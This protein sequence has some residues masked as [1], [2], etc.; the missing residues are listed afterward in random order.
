MPSSPAKKNTAFSFEISLPSEAGSTF[1]VDPTLE[2]G[3]VT[4]S[5]DG[6]AFANIA[7]LP[8]VIGSGSTLTVA[9]TS[10]EMNADRVVVA[11]HDAAGAE[12][13][14]VNVEIFTIAENG[15]I[16]ANITHVNEIAIDGTGT[17][18]DPWGPV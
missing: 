8:T 13:C 2:E 15:A 9:L 4:V 10:G 18:A 12:W 7:S 5:L 3:D 16:D 1:Q 11:F 17:P 14:D 6:G